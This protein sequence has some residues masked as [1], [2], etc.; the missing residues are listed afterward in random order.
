MLKKIFIL[1]CIIT[2]FFVSGKTIIDTDI[3][4]NG[5]FRN[6]DLLFPN[7]N[8][9]T[10]TIKIDKYSIVVHSFYNRNASDTVILPHGY[11]D[12]V[13][14]LKNLIKILLKSGYSV[15]TYDQPGHGLSSGERANIDNFNDYTTVLTKIN[16][17]ISPNN[18]VHIVGHSTGCSAIIKG[19]LEDNLNNVSKI[20]LVSPLVRSNYWHISKAGNNV[21]GLFTK[22]IPRVFRK[23]SS[24][25]NYLNFIKNID[26]LQYK[27]FPLQW[28]KSLDNWNKEIL[29]LPKSNRKLLVIQGDEDTTVD[30]RYNINFI[31][32]KFPNSKVTY[33]SDGRHQ[34][35]NEREEIKEE[36]FNNIISYLVK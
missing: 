22:E 23:N 4:Y 17:L 16:N 26:A 6:Y 9:T 33:I 25:S 31:S 20:V 19:L 11:Y 10:D 30:W 1:I 13:G 18:N 21:I 5:V 8:H 24:D 36:V 3:E 14:I 34:L 7:I 29:E 32:E 35:Y 12:H 15:I 28:F 27:K 2:S